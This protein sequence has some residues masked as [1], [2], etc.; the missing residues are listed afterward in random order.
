TIAEL[1]RLVPTLRAQSAAAA[2]LAAPPAAFA[3]SGSSD[4]FGLAPIQR[5]FFEQ[6]ARAPNHWN[7]SVLFEVAEPLD[8]DR[9]SRALERVSAEHPALRLRFSTRAGVT[10]QRYSQDPEREPCT[11]IDL[12][13]EAEPQAS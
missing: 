13:G 5:W 12:S 1:A 7:Q 8:V 9:L 2:S 4:E 6:H 10:Q 11:R 3:A